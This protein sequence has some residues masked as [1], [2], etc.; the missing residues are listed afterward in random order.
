MTPDAA[1]LDNLR[2][3]VELAPVSWW[4][5]AAGWW[6]VIGLSVVA[7][8]YFVFRT[9]RKW[10]ANAYR[11]AAIS[12]LRENDDVAIVA[13]ILKRTALCAYPRTKVASLSGEAWC[14]WLGETG[15][16]EVS[17]SVAECLT[18]GVFGAASSGKSEE[19][20]AFAE[21]WIINHQVK[22]PANS[23]HDDSLSSGSGRQ[24]KNAI[25][26]MPC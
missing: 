26:N 19:L 24:H 22:C 6:V 16:Q 20:A 21:H 11:R 18:K 7:G 3:I 17:D 2:D 14:R 10:H 9:L 5:L 8:S 4:P 12:E 1:S 23:K 15:D 13:D 25:E